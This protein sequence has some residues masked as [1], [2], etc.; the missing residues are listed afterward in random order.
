MSEVQENQ[1]VHMGD[2]VRKLAVGMVGRIE[3]G[4]VTLNK[5]EESLLNLLYDKESGELK[6]RDP[7]FLLNVCKYF[8]GSITVE[9]SA[10]LSFVSSLQRGKLPAIPGDPQEEPVKYDGAKKAIIDMD[11]SKREELR[12]EL[13]VGPE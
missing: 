8:R 4:A 6:N 10:V 7:Q 1:M 13:E 9:T 12:K 11:P 3:N 5:L 2:A